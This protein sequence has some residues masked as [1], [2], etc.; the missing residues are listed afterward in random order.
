MSGTA[1]EVN[2]TPVLLETSRALPLVHMSASLFTGAIEDPA[3]KEGLTRLMTR[4][5]R[6]TGG[7]LTQQELDTRVDSLGGSLGADI[8]HSTLSFNGTVIARNLE[9]FI[10]LCI[11]VIARPGFADEEL[12]HLRRETEAEIVESRDNDRA[13]ARRW[14]QRRMFAGH[15]YGR[16]VSGRLSTLPG[17]NGDDVRSL[18]ARA[19]VRKNLVLAFSGDIDEERAKAVAA[20]LLAALPDGAPLEDKVADPEGPR[21]RSLVL[22]DKPERTQT[23][24]LIGG[25]GTHPKDADH[26]A[27]HVANTVFGGTFTARL[28]KEIRSKRGWSYG[29]YSSLPI[30]RHRQAFS[31]W[32]FPKA[33]DAEACIKVELGLLRAWWEKGITE[34]ELSWAKRYLVRS[35]AFSVDTPSKRV[36]LLLDTLI[37]GLPA[38]Y[39]EGYLENVAAVTLDQ[40]NS[41]IRER[42]SPDNLL[43]SVVGTASEIGDGVRSAID[44]LGEHEVVSFDAD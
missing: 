7:G 11:D 29:A 40:V 42:I 10:D 16:S 3:G 15:A 13:L 23:Q 14:F 1:I 22:V 5:M 35:H 4:A 25:L 26:I 20:R 27:L 18:H 38:G 34:R 8:A 6:R 31:L 32:T 2:G 17:M 30:D 9:P 12:A 36:G 28:M 44:G 21:G 41:A 19:F 37:Y 43:F 39:Y 24:I 33:S